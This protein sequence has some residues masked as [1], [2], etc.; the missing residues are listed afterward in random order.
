[1]ATRPSADRRSRKSSEKSAAIAGTSGRQVEKAK[2]VRRYAPHLEPK[3]ASGEMSLSAAYE[4]ARRLAM[5]ASAAGV[6]L[7]PRSRI[8]GRLTPPGTAPCPNC[9]GT[10]RIP[11]ENN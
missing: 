11:K 3:V 2:T 7:G 5:E 1:M 10:G 8:G 9:R 6:D 4:E